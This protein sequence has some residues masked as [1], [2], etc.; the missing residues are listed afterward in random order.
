[1]R[2]VTVAVIGLG[3]SGRV[4][5]CRY[6]A[7]A[8]EAWRLVAVADPSEQRRTSARAE[9]GC[10]AYPDYRDIIA[11]QAPDFV[12]NASPNHLHVPISLD[13]LRHG[14]NVISEKPVADRLEG[15][16]TLVRAAAEAGRTFAVF[17]DLRFTPHFMQLRK[18]LD[19]GVLGRILQVSIYSNNYARKWDWRTLKAN[20][21]G[22]LLNIAPHLIDQAV[23]LLGERAR[24]RVLCRLDP[25]NSF[26]DA[27]NY[28]K[29]VLSAPDRPLIDIE[30]SSS[31]AC[32]PFRYC[33]QGVTG[34]LLGWSNRMSW[35][36]FRPDE[37]PKR[38]LVRVP[39]ADENGNPAFCGENL[40]W[41]EETWED[42]RN[43]YEVAP[44]LFYE[45]L[46]QS[47][48]TGRPFDVTLQQ[49]RQQMEI[50]EECRRQ[51]GTPPQA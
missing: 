41:Y 10:A 27:D 34:G 39:L 40:R 3:M 22:N 4:I 17:Q 13:L 35:R 23:L 28:V 49:V 36:Y 47:W 16:D 8:P 45:G 2:A 12:V 14:L 21:G 20:G 9:Y 25:A 29:I 32:P 6:F 26:G 46:H 1:M 51:D 42:A 7:S 24:P 15:F 50:V 31:C 18:V 19:S 5:H 38:E 48:T 11:N 30:A 37:A 44:R 33:V 43:E